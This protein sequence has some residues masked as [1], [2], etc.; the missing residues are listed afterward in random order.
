MHDETD[1]IS[2]STQNSDSRTKPAFCPRCGYNLQGSVSTWIKAGCCPFFGQCSECGL[3][4]SWR[5]VFVESDHPW[6]FEYH[7]RRKP[8][9]SFLKTIRLAFKPSVFWQNITMSDKM[10]L[11]VQVMILLISLLMLLITRVALNIVS[12]NVLRPA[13]SVTYYLDLLD[14]WNWGTFSWHMVLGID[15]QSIIMI[16]FCWS[17]VLIL[18]FSF[19]P[20]SIRRSKVRRIHLVRVVVYSLLPFIMLLLV[21]AVVDAALTISK[22]YYFPIRYS[23]EMLL[24]KYVDVTC[25][26]VWFVWITVCNWMACKHYLKLS[27]ALLIGLLLP[28]TSGLL[29]LTT[30]VIVMSMIAPGWLWGLNIMRGLI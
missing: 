11:R 16:V 23:T 21:L 13:G 9:Q 4:L 24:D 12:H 1:K 14:Q 6:L 29:M 25:L 10:S 27:N 2:P 8:I 19:L 30:Y 15:F 22:E 20:V 3:K 18:C 28:V 7:W 5:D 17:F 26:F